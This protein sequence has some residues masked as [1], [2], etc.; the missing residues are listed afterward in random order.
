MFSRKTTKLDRNFQCLIFEDKTE[1]KTIINF[2]KS[3]YMEK[4]KKLKISFLI[5]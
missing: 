4:I 1:S 3:S 2:R 5:Q